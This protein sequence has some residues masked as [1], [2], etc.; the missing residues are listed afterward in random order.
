MVVV[1]WF[2]RTWQSALNEE[3]PRVPP[4][5]GHLCAYCAH[6]VHDDDRGVMV[7]TERTGR[8]ALESPMHLRCYLDRLYPNRQPAETKE[9][10]I[11]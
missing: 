2:G 5:T 7:R 11:A 10:A 9:A 6:A 3:M 1:A 4:P 8:D